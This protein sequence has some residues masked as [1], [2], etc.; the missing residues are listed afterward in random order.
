MQFNYRTY[1]RF[2][3]LIN[4]SSDG[5]TLVV[6]S[7]DG[8]CSIINFK[9]GELGQIYQPK[10][11]TDND[12]PVHKNTPTKENETKFE[13]AMDVEDKNV[14]E[15]QAQ[16]TIQEPMEVSTNEDS[17]ITDCRVGELGHI[18]QPKKPIGSIPVDRK[19]PT[20]E[21]EIKV[22]GVMDVEDNNVDENQTKSKDETMEVSSL[23]HDKFSNLV[24][25][26]PGNICEMFSAYTR[27]LPR[28][29]LN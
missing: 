23:F 13:G 21:N 25:T 4:R 10:E 15:K 29:F 12:I 11:P 17:S 22:N 14:D 9:S 28:Q 26:K 1:G 3:F 18:D 8:Y 24:H 6:S 2:L 27:K 16:S 5:N 19:T 20:K 7:T